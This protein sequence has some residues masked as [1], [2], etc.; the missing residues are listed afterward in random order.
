[1]ISKIIERIR[2]RGEIVIYGDGRQTRDFLHVRDAVSALLTGLQYLKKPPPRSHVFNVC[3]GRGISINQLA[4][5]IGAIFERQVVIRYDAA[6]PGDIRHSIGDPAL[7]ERELKFRAQTPFW[8]TA[9]GSWP[10]ASVNGRLSTNPLRAETR[11][12]NAFDPAARAW[13]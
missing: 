2:A 13:T 9:Y 10:I 6:R 3:T 8:Q 4:H 11:T 12:R 5:N 1:M 7:A